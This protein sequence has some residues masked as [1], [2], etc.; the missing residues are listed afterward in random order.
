MPEPAY[1]NFLLGIHLNII[2]IMHLEVSLIAA[3]WAVSFFCAS[4]DFVLCNTRKMKSIS[5]VQ[6]ELRY[7]LIST[8][9][10][11]FISAGNI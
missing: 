1:S 10:L 5:F 8:L 4:P 3:F 9:M 11:P 6:S 7:H 2:H